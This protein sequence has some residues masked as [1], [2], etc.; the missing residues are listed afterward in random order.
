MMGTFGV[1]LGGVA[2]ILLLIITAWIWKKHGPFWANLFA[3]LVSFLARSSIIY[4]TNPL[5]GKIIAENQGTLNVIRDSYLWIT[6]W[7]IMSSAAFIYAEM[8][9][10][11]IRANFTIERKPEGVPDSVVPI[12]KEERERRRA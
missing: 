11:F 1:V 9:V 5:N 7:V 12:N 6:V 2:V 4:Y 10:P 8:L 3:S